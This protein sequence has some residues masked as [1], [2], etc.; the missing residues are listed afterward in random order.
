MYSEVR[1]KNF[2]GKQLVSI[3]MNHD[4][5]QL[6]D[7]G[8]RIDKLIDIFDGESPRLTSMN[9]E[10]DMKINLFGTS[11]NSMEE[12][13]TPEPPEIIDEE[14][15]AINEGKNSSIENKSIWETELYFKYKATWTDLNE[16][17]DYNFSLSMNN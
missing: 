1:V 12:I 5:Y 6:N 2:S 7:G 3:R 8:D 10:N 16:K 9:I 14:P 15:F 4:F 13:P 17:W 11:I